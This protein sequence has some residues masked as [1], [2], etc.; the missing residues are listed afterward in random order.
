MQLQSETLYLFA[1][2]FFIAV[3]LTPALAFIVS[4][5]GLLGQG[6]EIALRGAAQRWD[7][8]RTATSGK[9]A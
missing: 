8:R 4:V 5:F 1:L 9:S 7:A 3:L 6:V 2:L